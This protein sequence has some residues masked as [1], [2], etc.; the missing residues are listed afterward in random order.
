MPDEARSGATGAAPRRVFGPPFFV[1]IRNEVT[2]Y[3]T[4]KLISDSL[5]T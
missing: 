3:L 5:Y 1:A 2:I 4:H